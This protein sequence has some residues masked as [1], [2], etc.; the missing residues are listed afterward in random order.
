MRNVIR[1]LSVVVAG[2]GR[3]V[4]FV[5]CRL[6]AQDGFV[7]AAFTRMMMMMMNI[8]SMKRLLCLCLVILLFEGTLGRI[9]DFLTDIGGIPFDNSYDIC[10]ENSDKL[11]FALQHN[12]SGKVLRFPHNVTFHF[13]HGIVAMEVNDT[14]LEIDG[15][16][17]FERADLDIDKFPH[18]FPACI[19]V[20]N[21]RNITV[22]SNYRGL[23][24]GR[25]SQW[26]GIPMIGYLQTV[27]NR[28]RLLRFN[29]TEDLLIEKIILQ[30]SPYHTLYLDAV[31]RVEVRD[32]SIVARRTEEDG[33]TW[34]D[35][36]AFNT[37]GIDIS[38]TNVWVH[39]VDIWVQDDCIAV[40]DV[41]DH[42]ESLY[43][44]P[45]LSA[46]MTFERINATGL[47]F[48]IG[49]IQGTHV[50]NITFRNSYLHKPVKGIYLKFA[51]RSK[52]VR[53]HNRTSLVEDIFYENI[54]IM[55]P[56]QWPI[57]IGPA[58]QADSRNPCHPNPCSLCW[59]MTLGS[60]CN[61]VPRNKFSN[62]ALKNVIIHNP[63]MATGVLLG[64]A[65]NTIDNVLFDSVRV[66]K[67]IP[68][69]IA[70]RPLH[71]TFPGTTQPVHD[72]FVPPGTN[73]LTRQI[74]GFG[75]FIYD[76][77]VKVGHRV[78]TW[79]DR[80]HLP[81]LLRLAQT[82]DGGQKWYILY[83]FEALMDT[84][85]VWIVLALGFVIAG[86]FS[87]RGWAR[88]RRGFGNSFQ[89]SA[90]DRGNEAGNDDNEATEALISA[91]P[92]VE[93][94]FPRLLCHLGYFAL[95][96]ICCGGALYTGTFPFRKPKWERTYRYYA[97]ESVVNGMARGNTWPVPHCF[98][99]E[100]PPWWHGGDSDDDGSEEHHHHHRARHGSNHWS[101]QSVDVDFERFLIMS[102]LAL[103]VLVM[104]LWKHWK[105]EQQRSSGIP[106]FVTVEAF[107]DGEATN[108]RE[109]NDSR[110]DD[111]FPAFEDSGVGDTNDYV[112][113]LLAP[114]SSNISE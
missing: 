17:R 7:Y 20:V 33:H 13:H 90:S 59:P 70:R 85:W 10:Q 6:T 65:D 80:A 102:V 36:T 74:T 9:L 52:G 113:P 105:E 98:K 55:E 109:N 62:I 92:R 99:R 111:G 46:N 45:Y 44:P 16:L 14:I 24:D 34:V 51:K 78:Q 40:K 11:S 19:T 2:F 97:C 23:I 107:Q 18:P 32:M 22:T 114:I 38:G 71:E 68:P 89:R 12:A 79:V 30:D 35:L 4:L 96:S 54:T 104:A 84:V 60:K 91:H 73:F 66:T 15:T 112:D 1:E 53:Q 28:P 94:R 57:W 47:G 48:V 8:T 72:Q 64:N 81:F 42:K 86:A 61:V 39:D 25:G 67:G 56:Q 103:M 77:V 49:S 43:N 95:I 58:Q 50:K 87:I 108:L 110:V 37:D 93:T 41:W 27:E 26:W 21:S 82:Q 69:A 83:I 31:N 101:P 63:Q 76:L 5:S 88:Y 106:S 29:T 75:G 3:A 100:R